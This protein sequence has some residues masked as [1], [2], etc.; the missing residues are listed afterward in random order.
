MSEA[1]ALSGRLNW[2]RAGVLGA[3]DGIASV[4]AVTIGV[5]SAN[6]AAAHTIL[7][8]GIVALIG[9]AFSMALGEYVSVSSQRDGQIAA[10]NGVRNR[11]AEVNPWAAAFASAVAFVAGGIFPL[12][13]TTLAPAAGKIWFGAAVT[14]LALALAGYL[15]ARLGRARLG[16]SIVRVV[17]G[18][19]LALGL[20]FVV[21]SLLG[22]GMA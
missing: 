17:L 20:T 4:A 19:S 10:N 15:S 9:G 14:V 2:L 11:A 6:P 22:S 12:L 18:G 21:G 3:N 13:A 1:G 7:V 16:R 8:A 5:A